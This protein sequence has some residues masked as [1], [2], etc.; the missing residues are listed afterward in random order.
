MRRILAVIDKISGWSGGVIKYLMFVIIVVLLYEIVMRYFFN[1][2]TI[3]AHEISKICFGSASVLMCAYCLLHNE[4][5][6]IDVIYGRFSPRKRATID[7]FT[8]LFIFLFVTLLVVYGIPFTIESFVSQEVAHKQ[9]FRP[10]YWPWKA[11]IPLAGLMALAQGLAH[12][13]R[14]LH[15]VVTGRELA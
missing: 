10:L 4:H 13:I 11:C 3:W 9:V 12:W 7:L 6:R 2:P 14:A 15:L 8:Y 1:A 5:I